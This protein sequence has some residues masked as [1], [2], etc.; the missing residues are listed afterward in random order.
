ME[1]IRIWRICRREYKET[2]FTGEGAK[3]FGGRFNS[4]GI[5]TVYTSG[6]LSL[7]LLEMLVQSNDRSYL[8]RCEVFSVEIPKSLVDTPDETN[9]P[10]G[11]N[12]IPYGSASQH[13]GNK[14]LLSNKNLALRIPSV[15]VAI[16]FNYVLNPNHPDFNHIQITEREQEEIDKRLFT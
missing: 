12:R 8:R 9:L 5:A 16:E 2:A 4:E 7:S 13:F 14:W 11:W 3:L 15:V 6:S 10:D 1:K